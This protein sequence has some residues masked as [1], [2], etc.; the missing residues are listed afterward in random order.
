MDIV[1]EAFRRAHRSSRVL[2]IEEAIGPI[3]ALPTVIVTGRSG[4]WEELLVAQAV[5]ILR[6]RGVPEPV[7]GPIVVFET[8]VNCLLSCEEIHTYEHPHPETERKPAA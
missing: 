3:V 5:V 1:A 8:L 2:S 6:S 7:R 4:T